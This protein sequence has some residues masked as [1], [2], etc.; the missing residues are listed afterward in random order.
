MVF[1]TKILLCSLGFHNVWPYQTVG[2]VQLFLSLASQRIEDQ[3]IQG[4][5]ARLNKSSRALFYR[6]ISILRF[7]PYLDIL[8]ISKFRVCQVF[9]CHHI[10][11]V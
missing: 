11:F 4:W 2:D 6:N 1:F 9:V 7:Q 10:V 5:R 8:T 3:L